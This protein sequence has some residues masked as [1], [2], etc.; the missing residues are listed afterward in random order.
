[1][2]QS[3]VKYL[4]S[5]D[6]TKEGKNQRKQEKERKKNHEKEIIWNNIDEIF[7]WVF[8]SEQKRGKLSNKEIHWAKRLENKLKKVILQ[9]GRLKIA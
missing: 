1:V 4:I 7:K 5:H 9:N 3:V 6:I 2:I 8:F